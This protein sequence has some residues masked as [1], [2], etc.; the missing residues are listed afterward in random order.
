MLLSMMAKSTTKQQ[1]L[2]CG[3]P[4]IV[5]KGFSSVG[6]AQILQYAGVPKGSFYYYFKSKEHFGEELLLSYFRNYQQ[7]LDELFDPAR[8]SGYQRLMGYWHRWVETQTEEGTASKCL[9]VKLSAEVADLSETM[10]LALLKGAE[11][12]IARIAGCIEEG[13]DDGSISPLPA[14]PTAEF[15]YHLWLGASLM[16]KLQQN[17]QALEQALQRT[18]A[19]LGGK[20]LF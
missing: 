1:I 17:G 2:D 11:Q 9:V 20:S 14:Q 18:E 10:R 6:L 5:S 8:G 19:L 3:Y 15:L 16:S 4:L 7:R 12:I 13:I